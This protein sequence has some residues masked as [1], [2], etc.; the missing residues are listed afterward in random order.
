MSPPA[1]SSAVATKPPPARARLVSGK[2]AAGYFGVAE[3]TWRA[4]RDAG[5]LPVP[6]VRFPGL[7]DRFDVRDLDA[8]IERAKRGNGAA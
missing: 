8:A 4:W 7:P 1:A 5:R 2:W 6:V 3:R